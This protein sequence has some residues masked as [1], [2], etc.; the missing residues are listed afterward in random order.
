MSKRRLA[1]LPWTIPVAATEVPETGKHVELVADAPIRAEIAKLAGVT[2]VP[3]LEA[4]FDLMRHGQGDLRVVGRVVATVEQNCVVT[5]E[6]MQTDIDETVEVMF[7][8]STGQRPEPGEIEQIHTLDEDDRRQTL[9]DGSVDLGALATEFVFLGI[10][11][12]PRKAGAV[13]DAPP[14]AADPQGRPFAALAALKK[15]LRG[16]RT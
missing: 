8:T 4:Q 15:D 9:D 6:P 13:F 7:M 1:E 12:Y 10:N 3:R 2:S 5:L 14:A 16:N 11:P